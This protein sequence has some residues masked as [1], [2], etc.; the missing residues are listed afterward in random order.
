MS[1]ARE[2]ARRALA[3]AIRDFK[4]TLFLVQDIGLCERCD[5]PLCGDEAMRS[6]TMGF[7]C[8]HTISGPC[9]KDMMEEIADA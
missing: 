1:D 7:V 9:F 8:R 5:A 3:V 6:S 2:A 4:R